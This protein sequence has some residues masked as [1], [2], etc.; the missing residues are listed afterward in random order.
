MCYVSLY[1]GLFSIAENV[2]HH[3][4]TCIADVCLATE[5]TFISQANILYSQFQMFAADAASGTLHVGLLLQ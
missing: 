5:R 2:R 1:Q 4:K 3:P